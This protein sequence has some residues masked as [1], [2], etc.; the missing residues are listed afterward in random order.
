MKQKII[1]RNGNIS[2]GGQEKMLIEFLNILDENKYEVLLLIEENNGYR[3]DFLNDIPSWIE[4]K[5]LVNEDF[6]MNLEKNQKS[7]NPIRKL[8]Y[9]HLLK[10]KKTIS[11]RNFEKYLNYSDIIIDYDMGLIRNLNKLNLKN[12]ILIGWSHAG[13]GEKIKNKQKQKNIERYDYIVSINEKMKN[14]F[15]NNLTHPKIIK[16]YNFLDFNKILEKSHEKIEENIGDYIIEVGSLTKNKNQE[17]LIRA[18]ANLKKNNKI[19][20]KLVIIGDGKE[21]NRLLNLICELNLEND[22]FL[23]GQKANP[24]KY[25]KISKLLLITSE[26]ESFGLTAL[27]AFALGKMVI[28]TKTD[29]TYE[30]L[31]DSKYGKIINPNIDELEENLYFYLNNLEE[32]KKY[33][34]LGLL[35]IK[36]FSKDNLQ[37]KIDN[38]LQNIIARSITNEKND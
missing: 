4:L 3:N 34:K 35:R 36:D 5:F 30:I 20:E 19:K 23:L 1:I 27:E 7:K 14:G 12:K 11:I 29:G 32:R 33:E 18:F 13:N 16:I 6:M 25:I 37:I 38:F 15:K 2:I 26:N 17:L 24:Y 21:K 8:I 9:S 10:K 22:I 31:E 28:S